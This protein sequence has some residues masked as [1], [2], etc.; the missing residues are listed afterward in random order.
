ME[1]IRKPPQK[2]HANLKSKFISYPTKLSA[3]PFDVVFWNTLKLTGYVL[4]GF[5]AYPAIHSLL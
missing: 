1:L 2:L 4:F 5:F 3:N